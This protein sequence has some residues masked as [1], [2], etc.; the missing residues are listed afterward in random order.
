MDIDLGGFS[1]DNSVHIIIEAKDEIK[2]DFNFKWNGGDTLEVTR[3]L[4][5][6]ESDEIT[7]GQWAQARKCKTPLEYVKL[8][9]MC[10]S[11]EQQIDDAYLLGKESHARLLEAQLDVID[12]EL[13]IMVGAIERK[14]IAQ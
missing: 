6:N 3:D 9:C 14:E 8:T 4:W 5:S 12:K 7:M 13:D 1:Y 10:Y 2:M 11:L